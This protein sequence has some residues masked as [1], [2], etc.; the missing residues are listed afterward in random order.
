MK[1]FLAAGVIMF[2][3][4]LALSRGFVQKAFENLFYDEYFS[5]VN[6]SLIEVKLD[7]EWTSFNIKGVNLAEFKP[8]LTEDEADQNITKEDYLRWIQ[9]IGDMNANVIRV[10]SLMPQDFYKALSEYNKDREVPMYIMQGIYLEQ[11][12]SIDGSDI[13][14]KKFDEQIKNTIKQNVDYIHGEEKVKDRDEKISVYDEDVSDYVLGYT[15]GTEWLSDNIIYYEIMNTSK[16]YEGKYFKSS[17]NASSFEAYLCS[18]ADYLVDYESKNFNKQSLIS[19]VGTAPYKLL[20]KSSFVDETIDEE[21]RKVYKSY[22][23]VENI[24]PTEEL[25]TG[26]FV[27]YNINPSYSELFEYEDKKEDFIKEINDYHTV[28]VVIS[29]YGVP[30]GRTV[31]DY[32]TVEDKTYI[33]EKD[34]AELLKE[35]YEIIKKSECAGSFLVSFQ[36]N[37]ANRTWNTNESV[38]NASLI[39]WHDKEGYNTSLGLLAFDS[40]EKN[41]DLYV[42]GSNEEWHSQDIVA[43]NI[44]YSFYSKQ[45]EK[46]LYFYV[47]SNNGYSLKQRQVYI[48]LDVTPKS[49]SSKSSEYNLNFDRNVDFIIALNGENNSKVLV[50][51]YYNTK[52]F[53]DNKKNLYIRPDLISVTKNMDKFSTIELNTSAKVY[54]ERQREFSTEINTEVGKLIYGNSN[55]NSSE[56]N[57]AADFYYG[58][59]FVEVRIPWG[60]INFMDPSTN[61][62]K[63][64]Y[65]ENTSISPLE[66]SEIY[67]GLTIKNGASSI[68]MSSESINLNKWESPTYTE[69]LKP[70]YYTMKEVF[71]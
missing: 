4:V 33:S 15:L 53:I 12:K 39:N 25:K 18:I 31:G 42:D 37:W 6:N 47:K 23:D 2:L 60:L 1:K 30:D 7:D 59:D 10:S 35:Y 19:F 56:Y 66:I 21:D 45:D 46:Y 48:N 70:A 57:S 51:E 22:V 3:F 58:K 61:I 32:T 14:S 55:P 67:A 9:Y 28:P 62:I 52:T 71:S 8:G 65:Y 36:D 49:G 26:I 40:G 38:D 68:N 13:N 27:S 34:Q 41:S 50:Q 29:E 20:L 17:E 24:K 5:K 63:D 54:L 16:S 11:S 64:D 44:N 69:R 43:K